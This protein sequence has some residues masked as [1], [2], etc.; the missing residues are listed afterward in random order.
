MNDQGR[1]PKIALL[2]AFDSRDRRTWSGTNYH[3][4][5]ALQKHCGEVSFIGPIPHR[6]EELVG[7]AIHKLT[8]TLLK[9]NFRYYCSFFF[10]KRYANVAAQRL[11]AGSFDVIVAPA[12]S[13]EVAFLETNIPIV[14]VED[15][16][17]HNLLNYYPQF[18]NLLKRSLYEI[19]AIQDLAIKK[20]SLLIYSSAWAARSA[21]EDYHADTQKIHI[22]P[23]GANLESPPPQELI[24]QRKK[25]GQCRLL[26]IGVN[27]QRKGGD[28]A[29]ETLLKLEEI[30]IQ[31]E[32]IVCGCTPPGEL[33]HEKMTVIPFLDKNNEEQRKRLERLYLASDFLLLPTRNDC[34]PIAFCEANAFGLPVISTNTGGVPGVITD[35]EN[36]F[37]LPLSASGPEFA[38][39]IARIYQD[40][41][42]YAELVRS[43]RA[44]FENRLNWDAWGAT[45]KKLISELLDREKS[46][47]HPLVRRG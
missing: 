18:S 9:K 47:A 34:T 12:G 29:F 6:K 41:Q 36:G 28:I 24:Q 42:H 30:G 25:T 33:S 26:F 7:R 46:H 20:A 17:Y 22:I 40:D 32:L 27:W 2:T 21:F 5:Q 10:A 1:R 8:R 45:V 3:I 15:S 31:A 37:L 13:T 14:L 19:N 11:A 16:T 35:G 4:A 43:S 38:E 44:A 39:V 23:F